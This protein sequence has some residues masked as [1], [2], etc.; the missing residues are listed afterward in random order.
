MCLLFFQAGHWLG[1]L[2]TAV[3]YYLGYLLY[4][5]CYPIIV[6][7]QWLASVAGWLVWLLSLPFL[8]LKL[9]IYYILYA[10]F[11]VIT[12][13]PWLI[14]RILLDLLALLGHTI[15]LG[16]LIVIVCGIAAMAPGPG[17][18]L[19]LLIAVAAVLIAMYGV[20]FLWSVIMCLPRFVFGTCMATAEST[21]YFRAVM[22]LSYA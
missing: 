21:V 7:V 6:I 22:T 14:Y 11:W 19:A 9:V 18:V 4:C 5:I 16:L 15:A 12:L 8:L 10:I 1:G 13:I 2:I 17:T 20:A 3:V